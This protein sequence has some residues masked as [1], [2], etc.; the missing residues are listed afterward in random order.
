M[1]IKVGDIIN[2]EIVLEI[3]V[4]ARGNVIA[5]QS[6]DINVIKN[7]KSDIKKEETGWL[8]HKELFISKGIL[9][10]KDYGDE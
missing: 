6:L 9:T 8:K 10:K 5:Y 1:K 7:N 3:Y 4:N 2:N